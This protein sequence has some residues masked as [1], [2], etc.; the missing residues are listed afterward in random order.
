MKWSM[1]A[2]AL[3]VAAAVPLGLSAGAEDG[4]LK[5]L[6]EDR[7]TMVLRVHNVAD[8]TIKLTD[9]IRPNLTLM[10]AGSE[11]DEDHPMF[12]AA[13]EGEIFFARLEDLM[14][15]IALSVR[16]DVWSEGGVSM[17]GVGEHALV[18]TAPTEVQDEV[19]AYLNSLRESVG[20]LVTLE[21]HVLEFSGVAPDRTLLTAEQGEA[22]IA[23]T[24]A[25]RVHSARLTAFSGQRASLY[26]SLQ[27]AFVQDY[28]VEVAQTAKIADPIVSVQ[29]LGLSFDARCVTRGESHV[30]VDLRAQLTR[31]QDDDRTVDAVGGK[32]TVPA[33]RLANFQSTVSVP[34]G[35][36]A[37]IGSGKAGGG[38]HWA[39]LISPHAERMGAAKRGG[40]K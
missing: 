8:L 23:G 29:Q 37:L 40:G 36:Y 4:E 1:I 11:I 22:L 16:P 39:I 24:G 27:R 15:L 30:V 38:G 19:E 7:P 12:G 18:V 28:D 13:Q 21:L 31:S 33:H 32:V 2:L 17:G 14:D 10:P 35:G 6:L 34:V 25:K 9:F 26:H 5:G 3:V 20:R